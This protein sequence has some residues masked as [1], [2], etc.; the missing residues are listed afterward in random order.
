MREAAQPGRFLVFEGIEGAGKTTQLEIL[1]ERLRGRGL[2]PLLTRE[3]GGTE[4]GRRLREY[5][6][7][8][9]EDPPE[10]LVEAL[11]M[12]TDRADHILRLVRP[13]LEAGRIVLCDRHADAT[14]AYQGGGSGVAEETLVALNRIATGGLRP[15]LVVLLDLPPEG[16]GG[17][18]DSRGSPVRDRFESEPGDFFRRVR[19]KYL[20]LAGREPERWFVLDATRP[21]TELAA[22]IETRVLAILGE[23]QQTG[24]TPRKRSEQVKH[25]GDSPAPPV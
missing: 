11:L 20:E 3:P 5:L 21:A 17:R 24:G 16:S 7:S 14:L 12:V 22:E 6:L 19:H 2:D 8:K 9:R 23:R 15:D 10:P 1:A 13:A 18:L 25:R 4:L